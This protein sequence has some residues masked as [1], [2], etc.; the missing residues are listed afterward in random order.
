M[1]CFFTFAQL[2]KDSLA[3]AAPAMTMRMGDS[4]MMPDFSTG[5]I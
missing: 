1:I 2:R 3:I 5:K 4:F